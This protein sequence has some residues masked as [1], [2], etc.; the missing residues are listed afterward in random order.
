M[1]AIVFIYITVYTVYI[2]IYIIVVKIG[3]LATLPRYHIIII[4]DS[5]VLRRMR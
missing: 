1:T 4:G 3:M 5:L 2:I